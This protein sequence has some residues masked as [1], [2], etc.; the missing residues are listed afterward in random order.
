MNSWHQPQLWFVDTAARSRKKLVL[1]DPRPFPLLSRAYNMAFSTY[2]LG[3][4]W[5]VQTG[6]VAEEV[7]LS[8][9]LDFPLKILNA[10]EAG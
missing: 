1:Y 10:S 8:V 2:F 3:W 6:K 7:L 9:F 5:C 4:Y